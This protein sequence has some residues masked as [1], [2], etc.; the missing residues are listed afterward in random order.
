M[1]IFFTGQLYHKVCPDATQSILISFW[2]PTDTDI[3]KPNRAV[4]KPLTDAI[5]DAF[6]TAKITA[7]RAIVNFVCAIHAIPPIQPLR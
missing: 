2:S 1:D 6:V 7:H 3:E 4:L 5:F